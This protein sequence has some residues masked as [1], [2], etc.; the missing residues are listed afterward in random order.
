MV[1]KRDSLP[2]TTKSR[3]SGVTG[4]FTIPQ[5]V[6]HQTH[7]TSVSSQH[8]RDTQPRLEPNC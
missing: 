8:F 6:D 3:R 5:V 4:Y 2:R 1:Q 7:E